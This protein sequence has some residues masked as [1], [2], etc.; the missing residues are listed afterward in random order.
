MVTFISHSPE[1]TIRL[2]CDWGRSARAGWLVGLRGDLGAGKTQL[3]KGIA[4][5]LGVPRHVHSP[6][7]ALINPYEGGRLWLHH[8]DLYRLN[9]PEEL[10][11]AGLEEYLWHPT[12]VTVVEWIDHALGVGPWPK[13]LIPRPPFG[14]RHVIMEVTSENSRTIRYE[15]FG[16]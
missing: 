16:P 15:D 1:E 9:G 13:E 3:V 12:G 6:T 4:R 2:G 7:F 14:F 10:R 11:D 5:G 8:V